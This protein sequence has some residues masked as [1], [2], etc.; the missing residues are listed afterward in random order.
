MSR[1]NRANMKDRSTTALVLLLFTGLTG[2]AS[3]E[4]APSGPASEFATNSEQQPVIEL[5]E[6]EAV[7]EPRRSGEVKLPGLRINADEGY[8]DIEA[9]I[10]LDKG[11]LEL[12]ACKV[13][14]K[15]HESIVTVAAQPMHIH[16]AL[17]LLGLE[18]GSPAMPVDS[19]QS[20][21]AFRPP[22]GQLVEV[23][24]VMEDGDG[25]P[26]EFSISDFITRAE[27]PG[28]AED[29]EVY[30]FPNTFV[31]AGSIVQP[32]GEGESVYVADYS[33][34]VISIVT[35]GDELLCLPGIS[36]PDYQNMMWMI[37]PTILP[38]VGTKV[39][40]RLRAKLDADT[41]FHSPTNP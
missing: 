17:L 31:F 21:S 38:E 10:C 22:Q 24:L 19:E 41:K 35:F 39:T 27:G 29:S 13:G 4:G 30:E 37:D 26:R 18:S 34:H 16:I 23:F 8:V 2:V 11:G 20:D 32:T 15:E 1:F 40:L 7:G 28:A 6:E 3:G 5:P 33:G 12:V 25:E 9:E 36:W 14:T